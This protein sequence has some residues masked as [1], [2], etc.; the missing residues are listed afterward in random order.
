[1]IY[2]FIMFL[3]RLC[4]QLLV[5]NLFDHIQSNLILFPPCPAPHHQHQPESLRPHHDLLAQV[6][7]LPHPPPAPPPRPSRLP[8]Q[9]R[10]PPPL[11]LLQPCPQVVI[12]LIIIIVIITTTTTPSDRQLT[13]ILLKS[14]LAY[15][16]LMMALAVSN[17]YLTRFTIILITLL[18]CHSI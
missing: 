18:V 2:F 13:P 11:P 10:L 9:S 3:A 16:L 5:G 4:S 15:C 12:P 7:L 8:A 1:M 14:D 6:P 17:G